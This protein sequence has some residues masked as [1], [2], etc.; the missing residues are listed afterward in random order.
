MYC[1]QD[2]AGAYVK[3]FGSSSEFTVLQIAFEKCQESHLKE[4]ETCMDDSEMSEKLGQ[5]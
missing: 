1:L 5:G 2:D 3:G 4:G